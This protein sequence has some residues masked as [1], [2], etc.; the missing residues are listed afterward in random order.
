MVD[1]TWFVVSL[2]EV[3]L[4]LKQQLLT[5]I[6]PFFIQLVFAVF[7]G[8]AWG[9]LGSRKFLQEL[10]KG[11]D[12]V[13]GI[14]SLMID[15]VSASQTSLYLQWRSQTI[16]I[17]FQTYTGFV[18]V[19]FCRVYAL[20]ICNDYTFWKFTCSFESQA[21]YI[22]FNIIPNLACVI[23]WAHFGRD[24]GTGDRFCWQGCNWG[25]SII[26]CACCRGADF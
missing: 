1:L 8:E 19:T 25:I 22:C 21:I 24:L 11:A 17:I 14:N 2:I 3:L 15:Q 5:N 10:D 16:I 4:W 12:S 20:L 9:Y 26:L 13:N 18:C 23:I 7:N 6:F